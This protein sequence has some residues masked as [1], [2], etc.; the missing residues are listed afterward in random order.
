MDTRTSVLKTIERVFN[1]LKDSKLSDQN[2]DRITVQLSKDLDKIG[3]F[4]NCSKEEAL[5][6]SLI[7]GLRVISNSVF[8]NDMIHYLDCNPFFI[9]GSETVFKNMQKKHLITKDDNWGR[10]SISL[11]VTREVYNA[12]ASNK[13][14]GQVGSGCDS[15]Y[16]LLQ[17][18]DDLITERR[19]EIISTQELL[20]EIQYLLNTETSLL[21]AAHIRSLQ[22]PVKE[23]ILLLYLC[24]QFANGEEYTDLNE[25]LNL[26]FDTMGEKVSIKKE[27]INGNAIVIKKELV[28]FE[29]D[30]FLLGRSIKLTDKAVSELF[31]N[32]TEFI[33]R[34]KSFKPTNCQLIASTSVKQK[35]L[36]LNEEEKNQVQTLKKLLQDEKLADVMKRFEQAGI[37]KGVVVLLYGEPGTGK[38]ETVYSLAKTTG[39]NIL[40]VDIASIKDKY[41]GES[42]KHI[43]SLFEEYRKAVAS[44]EKMP[45][46]LFNESDALISKRIEVTSSVDQMNNSIQNILLQEL[47]NFEGILF[48]TSNLN[49][50]L[51]KAF[52]RRFLYKIRFRKPSI[53]TRE[54]IWQNKLPELNKDAF[55]QLASQFEFTGGQ[56]DN[57]VRKYLLENIINS[58]SP[59]LKE[60]EK[61]CEE[62]LLEGY[63]SRIGF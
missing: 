28:T 15:M 22:L 50:N 47:E 1:K 19:R 11:N 48:A 5:F 10:N 49:L 40:L 55:K 21:L 37:A 43:K 59:D 20:E 12:I 39:R 32:E 34:Q 41:V 44:F 2:I 38:T 23:A 25:M 33:D 57:V 61:F 36:F 18:T 29:N 27:L 54:K 42:E 35:K 60:V 7:F 56:I 51:D 31:A 3:N 24:Y 26:I 53:P 14:I 63:S 9:V 62:E 52:E 58:K 6:L 16:S 8:Y 17:K 4:F 46:L 45:I 30:F 13:P